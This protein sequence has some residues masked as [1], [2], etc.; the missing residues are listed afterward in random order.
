MIDYIHHIFC[1]NVK[2]YIFYLGINLY[3]YKTMYAL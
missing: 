3:F 2:S 1:C